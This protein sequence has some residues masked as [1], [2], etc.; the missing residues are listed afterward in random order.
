[1]WKC[2]GTSEDPYA[3]S[4]NFEEFYEIK[5]QRGILINQWDN[6]KGLTIGDGVRWHLS[7]LTEVWYV[8]GGHIPKGK[9]H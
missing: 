2:N 6:Y 3:T 7:L 1:M 4:K 9:S 5:D 8:Y